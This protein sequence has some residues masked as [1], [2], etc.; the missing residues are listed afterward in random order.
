LVGVAEIQIIER[1]TMHRYFV[2]S[3]LLKSKAYS[4][5]EL[6]DRRKD[7]P[8]S[9][10]QRTIANVQTFSRVFEWLDCD[11]VENPT[12]ALDTLYINY[13]RHSCVRLLPIIKIYMFGELYEIPQLCQDALYQ[14]FKHLETHLND[15]KS[16]TSVMRSMCN[17]SMA[18]K[19]I[20]FVYDETDFGSQLRAIFVDHFCAVDME[21][22][23]AA[24]RLFEYSKQFLVDVMA[25]RAK[26][27]GYKNNVTHAALRFR[28]W[29]HCGVKT[30]EEA[31][32]KRK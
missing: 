30:D 18:V 4:F 21:N 19:E 16:R 15:L 5:W 17:L 11:T 12:S 13:E 1:E 7:N 27:S 3:S 6:V 24:V 8:L 10:A 20:K 28:K 2:A 25:C 31:S 22:S 14:I 26:V 32:R 23:C 9:I 29:Q